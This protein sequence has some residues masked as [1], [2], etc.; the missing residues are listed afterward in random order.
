MIFAGIGVAIAVVTALATIAHHDHGLP[1]KI[2]DNVLS[3]LIV[4]AVVAAVIY[5]AREF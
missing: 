2:A 3:V 4:G 1:G 5:G